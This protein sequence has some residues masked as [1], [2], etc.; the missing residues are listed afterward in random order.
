MSPS[1][2]KPLKRKRTSDHPNPAKK[3]RKDEK[4]GEPEEEV[5]SQ[6]DQEDESQS[7]ASSQEYPAE[8]IL[9]ENKKKY[10]IKWKGIDPTTGEPYK[11]TWEL[12]A[13]A[14]KEL[15]VDWKRLKAERRAAKKTTSRKRASRII[16]SSSLVST[17]IQQESA[18]GTQRTGVTPEEEAGHINSPTHELPLSSSIAQP[19]LAHNSPFVQVRRPSNFDPDEYL[20]FSSQPKTQT[21]SSPAKALDT[22]AAS[23]PTSPQSLAFSEPTQLGSGGIVPD[24]QSLP[25]SSSYIPSTQAASGSNQIR[26]S[27]IGSTSENPKSTAELITSSSPLP[28]P[29]TDPIEDPSSS[30]TRTP[31]RQLNDPEH[32]ESSRVSTYSS[33]SSPPLKDVEDTHP[34]LANDDSEQQLETHAQPSSQKQGIEHQDAAEVSQADTVDSGELRVAEQ[35]SQAVS[36][37][38]TNDNSQEGQI[39]PGIDFFPGSQDNSAGLI[40]PTTE[41]SATVETGASIQSPILDDDTEFIPIPPGS[42][43]RAEPKRPAQEPRQSIESSHPSSFSKVPSQS[44]NTSSINAPPQ[45]QTPSNLRPF[46]SPCGTN[47]LPTMSMAEQFRLIKEA[48]RQR[49][50][51]ARAESG[52]RSPSVI[53]DQAPPQ[54]PQT[55]LRATALSN[56]AREI[57]PPGRAVVPASTDTANNSNGAKS[58]TAGLLEEPL[59]NENEYIVALSM[60]GVQGDQYRMVVREN[61]EVIK[62]FVAQPYAK[63]SSIVLKVRNLLERIQAVEGHMDLINHGTLTQVEEPEAQ[64]KWDV[65]TSAKFRFLGFLFDFLR[66]QHMHIV[67]LARHG[68]FLDI[69]ETFLKG[70]HLNYNYPGELRKADPSRVQGA[71]AIT[72]V[73]TSGEAFKTMV[74]GADLIICLDRT[75]DPKHVNNLRINHLTNASYLAPVIHPVIINSAEH[76]HR[77]ISPTIEPVEKLRILVACMAHLRA[78]AGKLPPDYPKIH[79]AAQEVARILVSS[80]LADGTYAIEWSLP[81]IGG[82]KDAVA[83]EESQS[84]LSV[85]SMPVGTQESLT[86]HKR[87]LDVDH[88][89]PFKKM[90][91]TPQPQDAINPTDISVTRI[92]DSVGDYSQAQPGTLAKASDSNEKDVPMLLSRLNAVT[93]DLESTKARLESSKALNKELQ[94]ALEDRQYRFEEQVKELLATRSKAEEADQSATRALREKEVLAARLEKANKSLAALKIQFEAERASNI[95]SSDSNVAELARLRTALAE[96]EGARDKALKSMESKETTFE[97]VRA[98]YQKSSSAA[99]E[100]SDRIRELEAEVA[101]LSRK[102]DTQSSKLKRM[103]LDEHQRSLMKQN[104][105]L[106]LQLE[107]R[108]MLLRQREEELKNLKNLKGLGMG[109]RA[110]SVPRSPRVGGGSRAASPLPGGRINLLRNG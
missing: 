44:L 68:W 79:V 19:E 78:D 66:D 40:Y 73:P 48:N 65:Q 43:L 38:H 100:Y 98:E 52:T 27:A 36:P 56:L 85:T 7:P 8:C 71:L 80:V 63:D 90:R 97:F 59:L 13:H 58:V 72:L 55:S 61:Q 15:V 74:R 86:S 51:M 33:A 49:A 1:K 11:P 47:P 53:P 21:A 34:N 101:D 32:I 54:A 20:R 14:N 22:P 104:E 89:D 94:V 35:Y 99:S 3:I 64:A 93:F 10:K 50:Q 17:P 62:D 26:V 67:L 110:A 102:A 107:N 91:M 105:S 29:E 88:T 23:E 46:S 30:A 42:E 12:K 57:T 39:V 96:A 83:F 24:S 45:L 6:E 77:C 103:G 4:T 5:K 9:R 25:G 69:A 75:Y 28:I 70:K 37:T 16:E 92:S 95:A 2:A 31:P 41:I 82:I 84:Q 60:E 18:E 109:T 87:P 108:E 81:P 76:I 106:K